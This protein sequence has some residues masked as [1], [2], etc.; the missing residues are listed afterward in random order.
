MAKII[1][2]KVSLHGKIVTLKR[3]GKNVE[4]VLL[5][6]TL[7]QGEDEKFMFRWKN[8]NGNACVSDTTD[9]EILYIKE[10]LNKAVDKEEKIKE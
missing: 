2:N 6:K 5:S 4:G 8:K 7:K 3:D 1:K 10:S 9:S